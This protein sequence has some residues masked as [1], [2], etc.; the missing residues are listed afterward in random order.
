MSDYLEGLLKQAFGVAVPVS[1]SVGLVWGLRIFIFKKFPSVS[2]TFLPAV[3][4]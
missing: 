1:Q 3:T 4:K 2:G